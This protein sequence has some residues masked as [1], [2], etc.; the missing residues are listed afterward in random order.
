MRGMQKGE[1]W[2]SGR[3]ISALRRQKAHAGFPIWDMHQTLLKDGMEDVSVL[4][5]RSK[6]GKRE[7]RTKENIRLIN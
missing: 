6:S 5:S 4:I 3:T 7:I 2:R 1:N